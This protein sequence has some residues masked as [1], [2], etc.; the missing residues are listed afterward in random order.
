M[1][2]H[3]KSNDLAFEEKQVAANIMKQIT[4]AEVV[5]FYKKVFNNEHSTGKLSLQIYGYPLMYMIDKV[6]SA[7][8]VSRTN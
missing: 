5:T 6:W 7:K 2:D 3:I 1:W 4:Q 8:W